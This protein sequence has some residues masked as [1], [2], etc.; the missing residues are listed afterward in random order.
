VALGGILNLLS[1]NSLLHLTGFAIGIL[2]Y[3]TASIIL[4]MLTQ[5]A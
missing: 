4:Q 5:V 3:T 2:P 1:G